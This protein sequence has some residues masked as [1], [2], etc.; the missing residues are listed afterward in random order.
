MSVKKLFILIFKN[1]NIKH[2]LT[3]VLIASFV[4]NIIA[5]AIP[6]YAMNIYDRVLPHNATETLW[7]L[8]IGI[9]VL[10]LVDYGLRTGRAFLL[11]ASRQSADNKLSESFVRQIFSPSGNTTRAYPYLS[12]SFKEL[13]PIGE[14]LS[15]TTMA[16]FADIPFIAIYLLT[17]YIIAGKIFFVPIIFTILIL[18]LTYLITRTYNKKV[19]EFAQ[20]NLKR[21][22]LASDLIE[23]QG[24]FQTLCASKWTIRKWT[25]IDQ[26]ASKNR[27]NANRSLNSLI[28]SQTALSQFSFVT[29]IL[30]GVSLSS[31]QTITA[32]TLIA[33]SILS[34]RTLGFVL[35]LIQFNTRLIQL[36]PLINEIFEF[37]QNSERGELI[38]DQEA[39]FGPNSKPKIIAEEVC[40]RYPNSSRNTLLNINYNFPFQSKTAIIGPVGS[41]KTTL[42]KTIV[43]ALTPDSGKVFYDVIDLT[44]HPKDFYENAISFLDQGTSLINSTV[45]DNITL[46]DREIR[47]EKITEIADKLGLLNII[48]ELPNGL[49][50]VYSKNAGVSGGQLQAIKLIRT[51]SRKRPILVLDEPTFGLDAQIASTVIDGIKSHFLDNCT[52]ILITHNRNELALVDDIVYLR[53]GEIILSGGKTSV[54][55]QVA[56]KSHA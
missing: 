41:G 53:M 5:L 9:I 6:I 10:L 7:T 33:A 28:F 19:I 43:G 52:L 30:V 37:S 22:E 48:L 8:T 11:E 44:Q 16:C 50:T 46:G 23:N 21:N 25:Q 55:D 26:Q 47:A 1:S 39:I 31:D 36:R 20:A 56:V 34:S 45:F 51:F 35:P 13:N 42:A 12:Q 3:N 15:S 49:D 24:L 14:L 2:I 4:T 29:V 32:G 27:L 17:I 38:E 40:F 54:L 18:S